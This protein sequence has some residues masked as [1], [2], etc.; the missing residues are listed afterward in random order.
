M[1]ILQLDT[2]QSILVAIL[3]LYLG[4]YLTQKIQ[5]LQNF[6]IPDAVSGGVLAS[7]IFAVYYAVFKSQIEFNLSIRDAFLIIFFYCHW[8]FF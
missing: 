7:L 1:N 8:T 4:K 5:F 2:R 3:V 6:N